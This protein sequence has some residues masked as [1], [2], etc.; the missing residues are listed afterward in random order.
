MIRRSRS[1]VF[2]DSGSQICASLVTGKSRARGTGPDHLT[3]P[4]IVPPSVTVIT[5]YSL[6][7]NATVAA[8]NKKAAMI[9]REKTRRILFPLFPGGPH[10]IRRVAIWR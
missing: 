5:L 3:V 7:E 9:Q 10:N 2:L 4:E 6:C 8:A 1:T